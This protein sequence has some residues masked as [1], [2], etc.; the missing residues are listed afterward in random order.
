MS[1]NKPAGATVL[2][3]APGPK[4]QARNRI[5]TVAFLAVIATI[6]IWVIVTLAGNDQFAGEKWEPF[7]YWS[8]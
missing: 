2:Y 3:D 8:T 4:A 1:D 6:A 7:T 5:I